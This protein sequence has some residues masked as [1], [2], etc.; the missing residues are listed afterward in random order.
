MDSVYE[1]S[2]KA[3]TGQI[4]TL[5]K[6]ALRYMAGLKQLESCRETFRQLQILTLYLQYIQ[7]TIL[8]AKEKCNYAVNKQV[9]TYNKKY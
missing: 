5:Q 4:F 9:H 8:Y 2:G 6:R 7:E 1:D 3:P